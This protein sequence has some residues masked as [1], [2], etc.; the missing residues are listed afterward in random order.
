[1]ADIAG[2]DEEGRLRRH[3]LDLVDRLGERGARVGV[4]RQVEAD[5]P[6]TDLNKS[7]RAPRRLGGG[8]LADQTERARHAA[9]QRSTARQFPSRPY[10]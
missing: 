3:R 10:T 1:V 5:M 8:S 7:K 2:V 6:V 9:V 4:G